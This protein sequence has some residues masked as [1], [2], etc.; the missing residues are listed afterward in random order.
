MVEAYRRLNRLDAA[1]TELA[2]F[3]ASDPDA[4]V[5]RVLIAMDRDDFTAALA[6]L[7]LGKDDDPHLARLRGQ[8]ALRR[9]DA[10]AAVTQFR[11][12]TYLPTRSTA[13]SFPAWG[14]PCARSASR[15]KRGLFSRRRGATMS[16]GDWSREPRPPKASATPGCRVELGMACAAAGRYQEARAW[17]KLAIQ[18]DPLDAEGQRTLFRAGTRAPTAAQRG[19]DVKN[20]APSRG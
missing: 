15:S 9:G 14:P 16:S 19:R 5:R 17:L 1:E 7:A 4:L 13:W 2:A 18:R 8:L 10:A 20:P 3:S 12:A 11:I 6:V